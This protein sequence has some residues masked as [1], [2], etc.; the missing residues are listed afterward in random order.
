MHTLKPFLTITIA[1]L[2]I[3]FFVR[4]WY[5]ATSVIKAEVEQYNKATKDYDQFKLALA[6]KL[7]LLKSVSP[8]ENERIAQLGSGALDSAKTLV[9]LE[10][11]AQRQNMLFGNVTITEGI[12][13]PFLSSPTDDPT[14]A[15][16]L[17]ETDISFEL[18]GSYDQLKKFL[19]ELS[20]SL[21]LYEITELAFTFVEDS[22]FQQYALTVRTYGTK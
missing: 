22:P 12:S 7:N 8:V 9:D 13:Q 10:G 14:Y 21:T 19:A 3:I 20:T 4:P 16:Q 5:A 18:I 17:I 11:F 6:E 15:P 1:V 2:L